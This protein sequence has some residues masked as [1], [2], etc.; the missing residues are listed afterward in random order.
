MPT[1]LSPPTLFPALTRE[2]VLSFQ[3]SSW[4]P[5]FS[6]ISVKSTIIRPLSKEF[7]DYLHSDGV[8]IPEGSENTEAHISASDDDSDD[9]SDES[10]PSVSY[11]FPDLDAR[12]R[13]VITAYGGVFPKLNFSSPRDAAWVLPPGSPLKCTSPAEVY[14]LLKSSDFISHDL[15]PENVFEGC[16]PYDQGGYELELVLRKW[17][18]IDRSRE[19]RCFVRR[20][21]LIGISQRDPNYYDFLNEESTQTRIAETVKR[22]W[23][24]NIRGKW[25]NSPHYVFDVLLTRDL[26][27]AHILDFN[28][29]A[30]RT[31]PLLFTYE[32][33]LSL[34]TGP[35]S[36]IPELRVIDS[37]SHP[38]A[39]RNAPAH[40]HNMI[41]LEALSISS[42][43][44]IESFTETWHEEIK[45]SMEEESE[46]D[47]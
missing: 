9:D 14:M 34:V 19:L 33:L 39:I 24:D 11:A 31:D 3:F 27:N 4:Y 35:R 47:G 17:Y 30:P 43:R 36:S 37:R 20:D 44:D 40:Q 5:Q 26:S 22:F 15:D 25:G 7:Q 23:E 29:F 13:Q 8:F 21:I 28:P 18:S 46:S 12:I 42:G 38:S 6:R 45:R 41:P 1:A 2:S 10:S 16:E 32:E